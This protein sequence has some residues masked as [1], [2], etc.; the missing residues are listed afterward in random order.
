MHNNGWTL[1]FLLFALLGSITLVI[2]SCSEAQ[3][4][5]PDSLVV[6]L[7]SE[8]VAGS[9]LRV[10]TNGD[11]RIK[12]RIKTVND[13]SLVLRPDVQLRFADIEVIEQEKRNHK[14]AAIGAVAGGFAG[15][16]LGMSVDRP[17]EDQRG[18]V[19]TSDYFYA[20]ALLATIGAIIGEMSTTTTW[21][22]IWP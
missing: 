9:M 10:Q 7:R 21:D 22:R 17:C 6:L 1:P 13:S 18:C 19:R 12:G 2:P 5:P 14:K 8:G 4:R 11:L 3:S 16:L 20:S 15:I